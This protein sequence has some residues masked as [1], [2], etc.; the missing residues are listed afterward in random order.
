VVRQFQLCIDLADARQDNG[1]GES[2]ALAEYLALRSPLSELPRAIAP[3]LASDIV[4]VWPAPLG[5]NHEP[6][7]HG[8]TSRR[9]R[10]SAL[11]SIESG[12]HRAT[13]GYASQLAK[14]GI[15]CNALAPAL[16]ETDMVK[17]KHDMIP[18]G[19]FGSVEETAGTALMLG[20][21]NAVEPA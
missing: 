15:T 18:V 16:I 5:Q 7:L 14:E 8:S 9:C 21:V 20:P 3:L 11:C 17:A 2:E 1:H 19:R 4:M 6:H 10:G 12:D 13:H